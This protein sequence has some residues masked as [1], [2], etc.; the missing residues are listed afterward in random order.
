M[1]EICL[2]LPPGVRENALGTVTRTSCLKT[3]ANW[4]RDA[5]DDLG[6]VPISEVTVRNALILSSLPVQRSFNISSQKP[7]MTM[8]HEVAAALGKKFFLYYGK[9]PTARNRGRIFFCTL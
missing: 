5:K 6:D 7:F 4:M 1:F 8:T 2:L 9:S 3:S